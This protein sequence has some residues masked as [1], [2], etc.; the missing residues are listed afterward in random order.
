MTVKN[1][2]K[3]LEKMNPD[4]IVR[5]GDK[6]G[7]PV[8]FVMAIM[9]DEQNVWLESES[10]ADMANEIQT[11]FDDAVENG[12]D[13]LDVYSEMLEIGIDVSMV[14]KYMGDETA[15]HMLKYC[16]EHGLI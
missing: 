16:E 15:N 7:E 9:N 8:L 2:I 13:E 5:L 10:D 1:L 12:T 3:R 14:R 11:R 4:A 6:Q